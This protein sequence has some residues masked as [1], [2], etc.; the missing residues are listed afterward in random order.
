M[1]AAGLCARAEESC[2]DDLEGIDVDDYHQSWTADK[3]VPHGLIGT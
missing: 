1:S 2:R 3:G